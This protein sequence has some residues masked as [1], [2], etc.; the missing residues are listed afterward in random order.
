MCTRAT[1]CVSIE[2]WNKY[3]RTLQMP[4]KKI[5]N[6][7]ASELSFIKYT[8]DL[9]KLQHVFDVKLD[10]V[11][12]TKDEYLNTVG[13]TFTV[14]G[15]LLVNQKEYSN[16]KDVASLHYRAL[17]NA[18]KLYMQFCEDSPDSLVCEFTEEEIMEFVES[19][20]Y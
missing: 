14:F 20:S 7:E 17:N 2:D 19:L 4:E 10:V 18:R 1:V 8:H 9:D 6:V 5:F 3:L 16:A 13:G 12:S 15:P 11:E